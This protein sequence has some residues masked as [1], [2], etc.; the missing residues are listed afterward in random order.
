MRLMTLALCCVLATAMFAGTATIARAADTPN[1]AIGR[2]DITLG[3][4]P[5]PCWLEVTK[6]GDAYAGRFLF[7]AGSV[8]GLDKV[9]V[10]DKKVE[11]TAGDTTFTGTIEGDAIKGETTGKD[12]NK[13][14]WTAKRFVAKPRLG[15]P[16]LI[17]GEG[18]GTLRF[19]A[20][21]NQPAGMLIKGDSRQGT[22]LTNV[23]LDGYNLKFNVGEQKCS[24]TVKGDVMEGTM[25]NDK[26][27][28]KRQIR[29]GAPI[30][31]FNGKDLTGWKPLGG[32][33][34][35]YKWKVIDGIMHCDG[36]SVNIV[37]ERADFEDF[38]LHVEFKVPKDGNSG[39]YLRGRYEIQVADSAG[40]KPDEH[41][42]AALYSRIAASE[43]A[44]KPA[45]EWQTYDITVIDHYV[46]VVWNGK[47]VIDN[48]ELE[49]IT[50]GA[51]NSNE[52]EPGPIYLQGDHHA[53]D[54]RKIT[55]TPML[56]PPARQRPTG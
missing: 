2:W 41:S 3:D 25:G 10:G 33:T 20:G 8:F 56:A 37:T 47:T 24:A 35:N 11:F 9:T 30:E 7:I 31:L 49:G 48:K 46:T 50:G 19:R 42:C 55:L 14:K 51:M 17:E 39:V 43:D 22:P 5:T 34:S 52:T 28:A 40:R 1:P 23:S 21:G 38:K 36:Q 16:W 29:W 53:I 32:D 6:N 44:G 18:K 45:D 54:Y 27:T 4:G 15:G 12:G 26:F 13:G